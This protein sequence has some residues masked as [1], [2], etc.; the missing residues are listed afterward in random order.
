MG[1]RSLALIDLRRHIPGGLRCIFIDEIP[2]DKLWMAVKFTAGNVCIS[3]S[4]IMFNKIMKLFRLSG[5][6]VRY[7]LG[8]LGRKVKCSKGT[9][10]QATLYL[11]LMMD[12]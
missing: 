9:A 11:Y 5:M 12:G 4:F 1:I 3:H 7:T 2:V 6:N 10:L 8:F